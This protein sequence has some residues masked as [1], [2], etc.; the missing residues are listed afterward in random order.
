MRL[1][2]RERSL[3]D[4]GDIRCVREGR[5]FSRKFLIWSLSAISNRSRRA[6]GAPGFFGVVTFFRR[7]AFRRTPL[8]GHRPFLL[9]LDFL[10]C[11]LSRRGS[12]F[13][14]ACARWSS[15][16]A[17]RRAKSSETKACAPVLLARRARARSCLDKT[18]CPMRSAS[19]LVRSSSPTFSL[20]PLS[21]AR[22]SSGLAFLALPTC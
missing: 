19:G 14:S 22:R 8:R 16:L 17:L 5:C 7:R 20:N 1:P 10:S 13:A 9:R 4:V 12:H 18:D 15:A 3:P 11:S 2:R 6:S 21:G